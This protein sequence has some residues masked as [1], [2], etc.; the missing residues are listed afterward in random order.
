MDKDHS[1]IAICCVIVDDLPHEEI[2]KAWLAQS[3]EKHSARL[4]VHA[5]EPQKVRS[6]WVKQHLIDVTFNPAWN[7]VEVIQAML[8]TLDQALRYSDV[9]AGSITGRCCE[10]FVFCTES[11]L[12][13]CSLQETADALCAEDCSW[14]SAYHTPVDKYDTAASFGAVNKDIV[15]P[16]VRP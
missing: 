5:K 7:S 9:T 1:F 10:R 4:F 15:P 14:L 12:P 3:N 2:W 8:S 6:S 11:C 16:K 13:L